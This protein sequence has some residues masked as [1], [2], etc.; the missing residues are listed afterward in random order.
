MILN[1]YRQPHKK[2]FRINP[3]HILLG[4]AVLIIII[5]GIINLTLSSTNK[6][7]IIDYDRY[8]VK[9]GDT[10][11]NIAENYCPDDMDIREYIYEIKEI[12]NISSNEY[13]HPRDCI[14]LPV[15]EGSK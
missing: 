13:I 11:W 6:P 4:I 1:S 2:N 9:S 12:N 5:F 7:I 14:E 15:Y 3:L 10:L 8:V